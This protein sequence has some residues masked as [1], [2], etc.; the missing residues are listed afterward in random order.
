VP[1][2]SVALN[3]TNS[4]NGILRVEIPENTSW[5]R[6]N[7]VV[8]VRGSLYPQYS[9]SCPSGAPI[10]PNNLPWITIFDTSTIYAEGIP[11]AIRM[12]D[13]TTFPRPFE[14]GS[15]L[16]N[17][18]FVMPQAT[19][20]GAL[21]ALIRIS[22]R[23]GGS[24]TVDNFGQTVV[25]GAPES[26]D[27]GAVVISIG[28]PSTNPYI[29]SINEL[30]PQPFD[31]GSDLLRQTNNP[32]GFQFQPG[33][34]YGIVQIVS[35]DAGAEVPTLVVTGTTDDHV[36]QAANLIT[37]P[38]LAASLTGNLLYVYGDKYQTFE[39][40]IQE[41]DPNFPVDSGTEEE[42][43]P[44]GGKQPAEDGDGNSQALP[45]DV[46]G[47]APASSRPVW[48]IPAVLATAGV[49]LLVLIAIGWYRS[50]YTMQER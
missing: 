48:A 30:L 44:D 21:D 18:I 25:L 35:W 41:V 9:E 43:I 39:T 3:G 4:S 49:L 8:R 33:I 29:Q 37:D 31:E 27:T 22:A 45:I 40:R 12:F 50:R 6:G 26:V 14:E 16:S 28:R 1:V 34:D 17:L 11:D 23:V 36:R 19:E 10:D 13:L 42:T 15:N 2:G 24:V 47:D 38:D 32:L 46:G 5:W 7:N 20:P